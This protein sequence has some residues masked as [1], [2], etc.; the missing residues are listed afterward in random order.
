MPWARQIHRRRAD[1]RR[2]CSPSTPGARTVSP[3]PYSVGGSKSVKGTKSLF[4]GLDTAKAK[5]VEFGL[6]LKEAMKTTLRRSVLAWATGKG[7]MREPRPAFVDGNS[8]F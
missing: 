3:A 2:S 1:S 4:A 5:L 8:G 7:K 6:E